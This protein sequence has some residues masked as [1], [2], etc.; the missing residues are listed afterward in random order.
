MSEQLSNVDAVSPEVSLYADVTE[1]GQVRAVELSGRQTLT[2]LVYQGRVRLHG[3]DG[4]TVELSEPEHI[5][6]NRHRVRLTVNFSEGMRT[7]YSIDENP[8]PD[9]PTCVLQGNEYV[10]VGSRLYGGRAFW[11]E[12]WCVYNAAG[13]RIRHHDRPFALRGLSKIELLIPDL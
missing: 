13:E 8:F 7:R 4:A 10:E 3:E 2:G 5:S 11:V 6:D 1:T 9:N 12:G